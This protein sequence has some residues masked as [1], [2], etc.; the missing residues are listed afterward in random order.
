MSLT[1]LNPL[2]E[3]FVMADLKNW[4]KI[5]PGVKHNIAAGCSG[6]QGPKTDLGQQEILVC[7]QLRLKK[8]TAAAGFFLACKDLGRM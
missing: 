4:R 7:T 1:C 3:L 2:C 6:Q 8:A 5:T